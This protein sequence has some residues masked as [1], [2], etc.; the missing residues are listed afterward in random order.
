MRTVLRSLVFLINCYYE[1]FTISAVEV[2]F[3]I[4]T[5]TVFIITNIIIII[6]V[7]I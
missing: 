5:I 1:I 3:I 4:I 7:I 2:V 6:I